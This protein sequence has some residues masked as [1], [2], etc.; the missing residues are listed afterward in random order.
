M[1]KIKSDVIRIW[2]SIKNS[3]DEIRGGFNQSHYNNVLKA[4]G[5]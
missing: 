1:Q 3:P 5:L 4:K 2:W